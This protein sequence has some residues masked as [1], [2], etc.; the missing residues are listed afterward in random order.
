MV[1]GT[2]YKVAVAYANNDVVMYVNGTNEGT[3]TSA[4][5]PSVSQIAFTRPTYEAKTKISNAQVYKERLTDSEL[6]A[7]TTI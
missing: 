6:E 3:D 4:S 5:I 2:Q 7:L 1:A